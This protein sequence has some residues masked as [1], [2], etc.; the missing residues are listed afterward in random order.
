METELGTEEVKSNDSLILKRP[1]LIQK[2]DWISLQMITGDT[3]RLHYDDEYAKRAGFKGAIAPGMYVASLIDNFYRVEI[4]NIELKFRN[5]VY[6]GEEI[7]LTR[8]ANKFVWTRDS[9]IGLENVL[10]GELIEKEFITVDWKNMIYERKIED[11]DVNKFF[12]CIGLKDRNEVPKMYIASLIPAAL[13]RHYGDSGNK[14]YLRQSLNFMDKANVGDTVKF[15]IKKNEKK[16][17]V[18]KG[19]HFIPIACL[20]QE[21]KLILE[22]RAVCAEKKE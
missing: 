17:E 3:N 1:F 10:V 5:V 8:E 2:A 13:L 11:Y 22:G 6:D 19:V 21:G 20:N 7:I 18:K 4:K 12:E 15:Y 14:I 9:N 16:N